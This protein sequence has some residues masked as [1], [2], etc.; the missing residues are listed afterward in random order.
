[1]NYRDTAGYAL[2]PQKMFR[3]LF[4]TQ[5]DEHSLCAA[6]ALERRELR[7]LSWIRVDSFTNGHNGDEVVT[8]VGIATN[9]RGAFTGALVCSAWLEDHRPELVEP[10]EI[11]C[12]ERQLA[13][14][15]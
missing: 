14:V 11:V 13:K 15:V 6:L 7:E 1:M 10:F 2:D 9:T 3:A 4:I 8:G 12:A 5:A